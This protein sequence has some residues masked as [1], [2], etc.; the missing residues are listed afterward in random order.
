M[1]FKAAATILLIV[2][3]TQIRAEL[4]LNARSIALNSTEISIADSNTINQNSAAQFFKNGYLI[5]VTHQQNNFIQELANTSLCLNYTFKNN[6]SFTLYLDHAGNKQF[7]EDWIG[8]IYSRRI[9]D[10]FNVGLGFQN[11]RMN[12]GEDRYQDF[13]MIYPTVALYLKAT[14]K[15]SLGTLIRNPQRIKF[16]EGN[17]KKAGIISC[18]SYATS[19]QS[20]LAF[21]IEQVNGESM[22]FTCGLEYKFSRSIYL[23]IAHEIRYSRFCSGLTIRLSSLAMSFAFTNQ[24]E[25]GNNSVVSLLFP[26]QK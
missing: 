9:S 6:Q 23:R 25:T 8:I 4:V 12:Y 20:N 16:N 14:G 26:I 21:G 17:Y 22:K 24:L 10:K 5:E 18:I 19:L 7:S 2:L 11:E 15:L 3:T 13:N 1:K